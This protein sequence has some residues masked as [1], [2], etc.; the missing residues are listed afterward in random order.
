MI[1]P[2]KKYTVA[3]NFNAY[4]PNYYRETLQDKKN[5]I[6]SNGWIFE[7]KYKK[8]EETI[9]KITQAPLLFGKELQEEDFLFLL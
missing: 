8:A 6:I 9:V 5:I 2:T 4:V 1:N 3:V 7:E